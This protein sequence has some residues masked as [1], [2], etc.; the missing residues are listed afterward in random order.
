MLVKVALKDL[1]LSSDNYHIEFKVADNVTA[2]DHVELYRS[3]DV[4]PI[5]RLNYSY[6]Y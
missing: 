4:A 5:G 1:G 6:G 3:G 2:Y